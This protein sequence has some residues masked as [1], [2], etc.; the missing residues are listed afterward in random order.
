M[1]ALESWWNTDR[2]KLKG[3]ADFIPLD[4]D[5]IRARTHDDPDTVF[6]ANRETGTWLGDWSAFDRGEPP[7]DFEAMDS[8][9]A[10]ELAADCHK[11]WKAL[12]GALSV[13][14]PGALWEAHTRA[15][16]KADGTES[17]SILIRADEIEAV[18]YR[19]VAVRTPFAR[20]I[21]RAVAP[22][23]G[24]VF[25]VDQAA[26]TD[27][28]KPNCAREVVISQWGS[29]QYRDDYTGR[30]IFDPKAKRWRA[31]ERRRGRGEMT[32][33]MLGTS[34]QKPPQAP[35]EDRYEAGL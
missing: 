4:I 25:E 13:K 30:F 16:R 15:V 6:S 7:I 24:R 14:G 11:A 34:H 32:H 26:P 3:K 28:G 8:D 31:E 19:R 22:E 29:G 1:K 12:L 18:A 9:N 33:E 5:V 35:R 21:L 20:C 23:S 27:Y 10:D 2:R 17:G